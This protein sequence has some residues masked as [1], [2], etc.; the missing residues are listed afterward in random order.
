MVGYDFGG[1]IHRCLRSSEANKLGSNSPAL[2]HKL[3]EAVLSIG[4]WLTKNDRS[5]V[6]TSIKP[7]TILGAR[8]SVA[9]HIEL[10]DVRWEPQQ[11]LAV[12]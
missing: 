1:L 8:L 6:H 11:G 10:L 7:G 12:G 4:S 5:G 3:V 2:V 9:F